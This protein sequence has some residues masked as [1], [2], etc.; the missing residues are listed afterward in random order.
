MS[1][2][3]NYAIKF[4]ADMDMAV[5]F[6]SRQLGLKLRVNTPEWTEFDT[7]ATT[8]VLQPATEDHPAGSCQ[9]GFDVPDLQNFYH[10]GINDGVQ[11]TSP[12]I[13]RDGHQTAR[14]IDGDGAECRVMG[15]KGQQAVARSMEAG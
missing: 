9:L 8:L 11:F 3:L 5:A 10:H 2:S 7:G 13:T 12:P 14:F 4:V 15:P 1:A 6:Y